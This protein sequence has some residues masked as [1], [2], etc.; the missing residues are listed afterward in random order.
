MEQIISNEQRRYLGLEPIGCQWEAVEYCNR[1][2]S[3]DQIY[4]L[5]D[6]D[7]VRRKIIINPSTY[8]EVQLHV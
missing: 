2:N 4:L 3:N 1:Q 5:F 8:Q 7:V 6:G